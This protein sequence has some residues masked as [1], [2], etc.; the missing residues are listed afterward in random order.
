M[1]K[2]ILI[3]ILIVLAL[4]IVGAMV[5]FGNPKEIQ[6]HKKTLP[7]E[8]PTSTPQENT[9]PSPNKTEKTESDCN[10]GAWMTVSGTKYQIIGIE[11]HTIDKEAIDFC[12]GELTQKENKIKYCQGIENK[13]NIITWQTDKNTGRL[14]KAM[15]IFV[16]GNQKCQR[17]FGPEGNV[18]AEG[19]N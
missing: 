18:I 6:N 9:T 17:M 3:T 8:R 2:N 19:C 4:V 14:Y 1:D 11:K 13:E 10:I 15:E 16:K 7:N 5:I 12:C